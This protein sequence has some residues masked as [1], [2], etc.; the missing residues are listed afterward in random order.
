MTRTKLLSSNP[1]SLDN[2]FPSDELK[3][4]LSPLVEPETD[5]DRALVDEHL[6][7]LGCYSSRS[8]SL[9]KLRVL[10]SS[11]LLQ[12][13]RLE[14]RV[15]RKGGELIIGWPH[16]EAYWRVRSQVGYSIAITLRKALIEHGWLSHK[17]GAKINLYEGEGNC[18]GYLIADFVPD[19]G[20]SLNFQ[21]SDMVYATSSSALKTKVVNSEIDDRTKA[22]WELWK[23]SPLT[24]G[25]QKMWQAQRKFSDKTF[26]RGGRFYGTWTSMR[27]PERLKCTIEGQPVAEVDVSG[28]YPTLLCSITGH[29]PFTT[30]FKDPYA[31]EGIHRDEVKAVLGSAIGGGTANQRTPTKM[32]KDAGIT[33]ERLSEIRKVIIPRFKC[34]E[35]LQ[36][37]VLDSEALAIHET[38]IM[39]RLVE[40]LQQPIF[41]LHDCLVCPQAAALDIGKEL[42][43]EYVSYCCEKGWKALAPAFSIE[44]DGQEKRL[45]SGHRNPYVPR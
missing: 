8:V 36:K 6:K 44:R 4:V 29:I 7:V 28:M 15:Q 12:A 45:I 35:A 30:R 16:D 18:N 41:I 10:L 2:L 26:T 23:K 34:L 21:S 31:V 42:Q 22:L 33:Q 14:E 17:V 1:L 20:R 19:K 9:A 11:F 5:K 13:Q 3:E 27:Q 25:K 38:E 32:I 37:G 43:K 40:R 39:M 24:F